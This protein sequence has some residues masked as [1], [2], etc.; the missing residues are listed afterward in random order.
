MPT[1]IVLKEEENTMDMT[2]IA[3]VA[4]IAIIAWMIVSIVEASKKGQKKQQETQQERNDSRQEI[5]ELKARIE[6]LE[7]IVTD[8]KYTLN[9][10]FA[11]LKKNNV[12]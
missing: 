7:K 11:N 9:Q 2:A 12:A 5:A 4:I 8:D 1:N 3:I 6:V 10:E